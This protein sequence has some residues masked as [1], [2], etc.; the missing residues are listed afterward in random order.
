MRGWDWL[1]VYGGISNGNIVVS[2]FVD[3]AVLGIVHELLDK[4]T[5]LPI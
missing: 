5:V 1:Y 2:F 3:M 4:E